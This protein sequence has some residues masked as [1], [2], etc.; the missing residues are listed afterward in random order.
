[1]VM[2]MVRVRVRVMDRIKGRVGVMFS[3]MNG[4]G[5]DKLFGS[6]YVY[7]YGLCCSL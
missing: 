2:V 3:G 5:V 7:V 6:G 4:V 1:M